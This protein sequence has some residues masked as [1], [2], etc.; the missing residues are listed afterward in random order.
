MWVSLEISLG[1]PHATFH[2]DSEAQIICI[3]TMNVM[4]T[5]RPRGSWIINTFSSAT[6]VFASHRVISHNLRLSW[7][8]NK[9]LMERPEC[10]ERS[11]VSLPRLKTFLYVFT[12][13]QGI[14]ILITWNILLSV[15][16]KFPLEWVSKTRDFTNI[17]LKPCASPWVWKF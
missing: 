6:D 16:T 17:T 13:E 8:I 7:I 5:R 11:L 14:Q 3:Y 2:A 12:S 10:I 4:G 9:G 15:Y 1:S